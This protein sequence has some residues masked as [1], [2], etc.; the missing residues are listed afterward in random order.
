MWPGVWIGKLHGLVYVCI[1]IGKLHGLVYVLVCKVVWCI[2]WKVMWPGVFFGKLCGL[3]YVLESAC[4]LGGV[5]SSLE[6]FQEKQK[7]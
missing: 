3:A 2:Y 1:Y 4:E 5:A 7:L 6:D